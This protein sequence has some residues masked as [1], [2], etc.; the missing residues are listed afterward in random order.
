MVGIAWLQSAVSLKRNCMGRSESYWE[1][2]LGDTLRGLC[3]APRG[4]RTTL[5]AQGATLWGLGAEPSF[6]L[7]WEKASGH[8]VLAG[9][10]PTLPWAVGGCR[11]QW[12]ANWRAKTGSRGGDGCSV[13]THRGASHL[14]QPVTPQCSCFG[15]SHPRKT[16]S[17]D[18]LA[19]GT[20]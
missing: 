4:L 18:N 10:T 15:S 5:R 8:P 13:L 11:K 2:E 20:S 9:M 17:W 12:I 14:K 1:W 16:H 19:S 6:H 3:A 7:G